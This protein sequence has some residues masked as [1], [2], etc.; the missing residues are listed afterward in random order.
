MHCNCCLRH[1]SSDGQ[2]F[3]EFLIDAAETFSKLPWDMRLFLTYFL[4]SLHRWQTYMATWR[5][6]LPFPALLHFFLHRYFFQEVYCLLYL[7]A[8]TVVIKYHRW[9]GLNEKC[10]FSQSWR[11]EA[12][13]VSPDPL[14]PWPAEAAASRHV[15]LWPFSCVCASWVSLYEEDGQ[16][17]WV[18]VPYNLT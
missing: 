5:F 17:Y 16:W 18:R 14:S 7:F 3:Q 15:L 12:Q 13:L 8:S 11:L 1:N 9:G 10:V 6:S 2:H 4:L